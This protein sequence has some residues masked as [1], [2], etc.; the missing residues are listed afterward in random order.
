MRFCRLTVAQVLLRFTCL[1]SSTRRGHTCPIWWP[2]ITVNGNAEDRTKTTL[3]MGHGLSF[4]TTLTTYVCACV[5]ASGACVLQIVFNK[6]RLWTHVCEFIQMTCLFWRKKTDVV[7]MTKETA[8][9]VKK[10]KITV[11]RSDRSRRVLKME[12]MRTAPKTREEDDAMSKNT[13]GQTQ[14]FLPSENPTGKDRGY[15][16]SVQVW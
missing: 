12:S 9:V 8:D 4:L 14:M 10:Q 5:R 6:F 15:G 1:K 2:A 11:D 13:Q 3:M 16:E 7:D